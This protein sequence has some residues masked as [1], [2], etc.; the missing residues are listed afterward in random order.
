MRTTNSIRNARTSMFFNVTIL[1]LN[2]VSRAIFLKYL[3]DTL[4]GFNS[5]VTSILG[6]LNIAEA[7]IASAVSFSLYKPLADGDNAKINEIMVIF[8]KMYAY[9][10]IFIMIVGLC[11]IPFMDYI[12]KGDISFWNAAGYYLIYLLSTATSYFFSYKQTL[13]YADQKDYV[14]RSIIGSSMIIKTLLQIIVIITFENYILWLMLNLIFNIG[15]LFV[16]NSKIDKLYKHIKFK[17]ERSFKEITHNNKAL[18]KN[19]KNTFFHKF[20]EIVITQSDPIV[21]ASFSSLSEASIYANYLMV[22]NG[23]VILLNSVLQAF[24]ASIGNLIVDTDNEYSHKIFKEL[25]SFSCFLATVICFG[26]FMSV[27]LFI[28][29]W[30]GEEY[31]FNKFII[32]L[33]ALNLYV[34]INKSFIDS[35]KVSFGIYW[36]IWAPVFE[37][38]VSIGL[39]VLLAMNIGI[40]GLFIGKLIGALMVSI[41]WK[42]YAIYKYGFKMN[43]IGYYKRYFINVINGLISAIIAMVLVN[44]TIELLWFDSSIM[45][46]ILVGCLSTIF[47]SIVF[48]ML[49]FMNSS[50]REFIERLLSLIKRMGNYEKGGS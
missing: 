16:V 22:T 21:I 41:I 31:V 8:K 30:I 34:L 42:P 35:Y 3:G 45:N 12:T 29:V 43:P 48:F 28:G 6:M 47:I 40:A 39:G 24:T 32:L 36:D 1:L 10:G 11:I 50:F 23:I 33:I 26:L 27:N 15:N 5:V 9:I 49:S 2:F 17:E 37:G 20:G 13:V 46:F 7:G 14:I 38:V 18:M 44:K 25:N 19:M 4:N